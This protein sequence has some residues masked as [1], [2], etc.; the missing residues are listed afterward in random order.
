MAEGST[1]P[2]NKGTEETATDN[3]ETVSAAV[4]AP[5]PETPAVPVA[6]SDVRRR[7]RRALGDAND[8]NLIADDVEDATSTPKVEKP[9]F[10]TD[11]DAKSMT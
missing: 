11:L 10:T 7:S 4:V 6:T 2:S 9:G 5:A 3:K 1:N 8:P